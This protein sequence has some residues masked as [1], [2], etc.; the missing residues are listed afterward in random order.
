MPLLLD[1]VGPHELP[2]TEIV[3][4]GPELLALPGF[5]VPF[6]AVVEIAL[7]EL[8]SGLEKQKPYA[9]GVALELLFKSLFTPVKVTVRMTQEK[10][11]YQVV[12]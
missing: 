12:S 9:V 11:D 2:E 8:E 5:D 1:A 7:G 6:Y 4:L 10:R 3:K